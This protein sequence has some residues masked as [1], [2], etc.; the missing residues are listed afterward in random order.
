M[1]NI[2]M[3]RLCFAI[4]LLL[5]S[6]TIL[7]AQEVEDDG[8]FKIYP[9]Q[10][11]WTFLKLDTSDGRI[12]QL[13]YSVEGDSYRFEVPLC[14]EPLVLDND[15]PI[16][17]FSLS[18]TNNIYNFILLD[19]EVGTTYQVQW[20][21][22]DELRARIPISEATDLVWSHG[23]A[24]KKIGNKYTYVDIN[25]HMLTTELYDYC[26]PFDEFGMA[27]IQQSGKYNFIR[28]NGTYQ[29]VDWFEYLSYYTEDG[30]HLAQ[31]NGLYNYIK[32]NGTLRFSQWYQSISSED[33]GYYRVQRNDNKYN[34]IDK[35]GKPYFDQWY[36]YLIKNTNHI[37]VING[38][39][40]NIFLSDKKPLF[41]KWYQDITYNYRYGNYYRITLDNKQNYVTI[42]GELLFNKWYDF[43]GEWEGS[44][45]LIQEG[46]QYNLIDCTGKVQLLE[47]QDLPPLWEGD[48]FVCEQDD[49]YYIVDNVGQVVREIAFDNVLEWAEGYLVVQN[50]NKCNVVSFQTNQIICKKWYDSCERIANGFV[51]VRN[52]NQY[53][54][55]DLS[56][57]KPISS[58]WFNEVTP[59]NERG[60]AQVWHY[61]NWR[62]INKEGKLL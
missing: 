53:N 12:W 28:L 18:P 19:K 48:M 5:S 54:F 14:I 51:I 58:K 52:K 21:Q 20:S 15:R 22:D 50:D 41:S 23:Y 16:G 60:F 30:Y 57:G 33:D 9:T 35:L 10:N 42:T 44:Y 61:G 6:T 17:R 34:Y 27:I 40:C 3:Q 49:K 31:R 13:Q 25:N 45:V 26:T 1:K 2:T 43:V 46:E 11:I 56:T 39:S 29:F 62:T 36:D 59:F 4:V 8:R 32:P 37:K 24:V 55:V 47:W 7:R 38:D